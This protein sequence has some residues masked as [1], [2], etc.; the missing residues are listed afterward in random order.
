MKRRIVA[1]GVWMA[2]S[3]CVGMASEPNDEPGIRGS[4][5]RIE[6]GHTPPRF[7]VSGAAWV[8]VTGDTKLW[9]RAGGDLRRIGYEALQVGD[10]VHVWY[11]GPVRESYPVQA[12]G[13]TVI[14][15][16]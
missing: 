5:E 10:S 8:E 1:L 12:V 14:V 15:E 13:G 11:S 4:I 7:L 16:Q 3:A 6:S 9:E 2:A